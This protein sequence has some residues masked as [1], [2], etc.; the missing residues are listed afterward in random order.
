M[1]PWP[2]ERPCRCL[3]LRR[4][5]RRRR[6]PPP[7]PVLQVLIDEYQALIDDMSGAG[8]R[9]LVQT[10][11]QVLQWVQ[12]TYGVALTSQQQQQV[13]AAIG[14]TGSNWVPEMAAQAMQVISQ[15]AERY[16]VPRKAATPKVTDE[17]RR[18]MVTLTRFHIAAF[19][20]LKIDEAIKDA[21]QRMGRTQ[22]AA[23]L[24]QEQGKA[25]AQ[26]VAK[27]RELGIAAD[28]RPAMDMVQANQAVE[29]L[30]SEGVTG[31]M[32][33]YVDQLNG[34]HT[35]TSGRRFGRMKCYSPK[36]IREMNKA[37]EG[38][39]W[40]SWF[41]GLATVY[42]GATGN[43]PLATI[44]GTV[45]LLGSAAE[46]LIGYQIDFMMEHAC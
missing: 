4:Q 6:L 22:A 46:R 38:A 24:M 9:A 3:H 5:P 14:F 15:E 25:E 26:R 43:I 34:A 10:P 45:S 28:P 41:Y 23:L 13:A 37:R 7:P 8:A 18:R 17:H 30:M 40:Y 29:L 35:I 12:D 44:T 33:E 2:Q 20:E 32:S 31:L 36:E 42:T 21:I 19:Q 11:E 1:P 27:L 39:F 16:Q